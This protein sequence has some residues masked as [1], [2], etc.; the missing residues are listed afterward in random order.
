MGSYFKHSI[1]LSLVIILEIDAKRA[2]P[3]FLLFVLI[4]VELE[5]DTRYLYRRT[6]EANCGPR[7]F[8]LYHWYLPAYRLVDFLLIHMKPS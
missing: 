3:E 1:P 8:L 6:N 4:G 5:D 7:E 2:K